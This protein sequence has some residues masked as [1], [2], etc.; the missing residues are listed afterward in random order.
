MVCLSPVGY[1]VKLTFRALTLR[2]SRLLIKPIDI[3]TDRDILTYI[4][5][6]INTYVVRQAIVH[7][8]TALASVSKRD[9]S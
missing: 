1:G 5:T 9:P 2:R 4:Y 6:Y 7:T 3:Q 8:H